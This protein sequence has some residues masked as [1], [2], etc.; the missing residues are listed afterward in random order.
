MQWI[1]QTAHRIT[2]DEYQNQD[3]IDFFFFGCK[4]GLAICPFNTYHYFTNVRLYVY[5]PITALVKPQLI[6]HIAVQQLLGI[7]SY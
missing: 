5:V 2:S 6:V 7:I 1:I 3:R 4:P